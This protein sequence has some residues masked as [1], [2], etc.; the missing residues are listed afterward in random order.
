MIR[1]KH[2]AKANVQFEAVLRGDVEVVSEPL[3]QY[4]NSAIYASKYIKVIN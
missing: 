3:P 4:L 1:P 2:F